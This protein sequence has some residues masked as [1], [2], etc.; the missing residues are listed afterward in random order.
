MLRLEDETFEA[1]ERLEASSATDSL[2]DEA[3]YFSERRLQQATEEVVAIFG[4]T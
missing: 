2:T 1:E 3:P 4:L